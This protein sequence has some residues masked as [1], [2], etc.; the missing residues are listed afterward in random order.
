MA[1]AV[2][3]VWD[4]SNVKPTYC[5]WRHFYT[6]SDLL[7]EASFKEASKLL[8]DERK[9]FDS[10]FTSQ[11]ESWNQ[12]PD[13]GI[14]KTNVIKTSSYRTN[15]S[16]PAQTFQEACIMVRKPAYAWLKHYT[17]MSLST[18]KTDRIDLPNEAKDWLEYF[19]M[20]NTHL[21]KD[22]K[23]NYS[24]TWSK[25]DSTEAG[26]SLQ[27]LIDLGTNRLKLSSDCVGAILKEIRY[28]LSQDKFKL[29][30]VID[31]VNTFWTDFTVKSKT[32]ATVGFEELEPIIPIEVPIY[33]D[34]EIDS[35]YDYYIDRLWIQNKTA[36]TEEGKKQLIT[37][38]NNN[39]AEFSKSF[40]L[41]GVGYSTYLSIK[42][43]TC[44]CNTVICENVG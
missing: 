10:F 38:S 18:F 21:I 44:T 1:S 40:K 37:L 7:G 32:N 4:E 22:I 9:D 41:D 43:N 36:K 34:Y 24:Y 20:M 25:R 35:C 12:A 3:T 17:E 31:G 29:L 13:P 33:S 5:I 39:P 23:T 19:A 11:S 6:S 15:E 14:K 8:E 28:Q 26:S 27:N 2:K 16:D 42:Y 30:L